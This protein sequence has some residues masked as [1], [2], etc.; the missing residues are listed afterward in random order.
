MNGSRAISISSIGIYGIISDVCGES[1]L[2]IYDGHDL[3]SFMGGSEYCVCETCEK[4]PWR[5]ARCI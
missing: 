1:S 3:E 2:R 4:H 5:R